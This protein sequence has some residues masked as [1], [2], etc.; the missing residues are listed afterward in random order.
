M[1][2]FNGKREAEKILGY[3]KKK[4]KKGQQPKLA[5]IAVQ[6]D[7]ASRLYI[8]N[9]KIAARQVGIKV[10]Y[11]ELENEDEVIKIIQALNN[12]SSVHGIIVQ[13]PLPPNINTDRIIGFIDPVKDVD[14]FQT[15]SPLPPVLPTA[16]LIALKKADKKIKKA[17]ALVNSEI[18]G[19]TLKIFLAKNGVGV[20]YFSCKSITQ[21]PLANVLIT[22]CGCPGIIK[23]D[24]IKQGAILIDAGITMVKGKVLGDID[25]E[26]VVK[27]AAFLTPVP[28]G[29]GPLTVALLLSNVYLAYGNSK[30]NRPYKS[31][32]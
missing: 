28:G 12:D 4:I 15:N 14:G 32:R 6:P 21:L 9:K 13:L 31:A 2:I 22:A 30:T 27:K 10:A 7:A 19:E 26:S 16:I 1:K 8:R 17:T 3:L 18:M 24:M 5:V 29:I 25:R 23:G 11:F 20:N